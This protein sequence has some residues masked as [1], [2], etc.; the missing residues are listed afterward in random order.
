VSKNER[1]EIVD[2]HNRFRSKVA[3]GL[4]QRGIGGPFP[5]ATNMLELTWNNDVNI[6]MLAYTNILLWDE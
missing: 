5:P 4:E 3:T 1:E 2:L 6:Q